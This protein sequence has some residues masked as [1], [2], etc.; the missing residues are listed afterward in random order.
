[1]FMIIC[2]VSCLNSSVWLLIDPFDVSF[3]LALERLASKEVIVL[4]EE[5]DKLGRIS[6]SSPGTAVLSVSD[7]HLRVRSS[8]SSSLSRSCITCSGLGGRFGEASLGGG[9]SFIGSTSASFGDAEI[10]ALAL[11]TASFERQTVRKSFLSKETS[12]HI[13]FFMNL[14]FSALL[15]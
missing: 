5:F 3:E 1:M 4:T 7:D 2:T 6:V 10:G 13:P 15:T 14:H 9:A 12:L 8:L 11:R